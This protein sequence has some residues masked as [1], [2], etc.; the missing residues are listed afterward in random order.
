MSSRYEFFTTNI[1]NA[2]PFVTL[3]CGVV[4]QRSASLINPPSFPPQ[5]RERVEEHNRRLANRAAQAPTYKF[6]YKERQRWYFLR[7]FLLLLLQLLRF[8]LWFDVRKGREKS[9]RRLDTLNLSESGK[10]VASRSYV[11]RRV[12]L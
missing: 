5:E 10:A 4:R 7:L 2:L 12:T 11:V 9:V 1:D 3:Y 8:L 6:D